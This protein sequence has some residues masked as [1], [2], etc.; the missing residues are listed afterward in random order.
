MFWTLWLL[1]T[2]GVPQIESVMPD[3]DAESEI[4]NVL[5]YERL[6]EGPFFAD[7]RRDKRLNPEVY[8]CVIQREGTTEIIRW[9]QHRTL[10]SAI[11]SARAEL[12]HLSATEQTQLPGTSVQ[13]T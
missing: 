5:R 7:F 10:E 1:G 2:P 6:Q 3:Q 11:R 4:S 8:H 13:P 12:K 9:S